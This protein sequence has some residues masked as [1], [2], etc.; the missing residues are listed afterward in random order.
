[1]TFVWPQLLWSLLLVPLLAAGYAAWSR[2]RSAARRE[3]GGLVLSAGPGRGR[4]RHLPPALFLLSI[5]LLLVSVGRP[6][7]VVTLPAQHETVVLAIDVS[8]SMRATDVKPTRLA[9]A[10][11]AARAFVATQ[12]RSTRIGLVTFAGVASLVQ[13]P[14]DNREDVLQAIERM[15][16]QRGTAIGSAIVVSLATIFPRDGIDLRMVGR[17]PGAPAE[18]TRE[19]R[20]D[21]ARGRGD[22]LEDL[23]TQSQAPR[24]TPGSYDSAVIVLLSDGQSTTGPE[25]VAAAKL[26]AER[27]VRVYTVG[28]GTA[29]GEVLRTDGWSM[30]VS[31]DEGQLK[32]VADLTRGEYFQAADAAELKRVYQSMSSRF[33]MEK[34]EL[35]IGALFAAGAVLLA[36]L[37][38]G[39]SVAWY[40][41]VL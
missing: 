41:R 6:A 16:P 20:R 36:L 5:A 12:P 22:P 2:R 31:L 4:W 24:A 1:M 13:P 32:T 19:Q 34:K 11:E 7:A 28:V 33:V 23:T 25:P 26:A 8:G 17:K 39:L 14:T 21:A 40:G 10:Q 9:A 15:Q 30:R 37:A 3:L 38:A 29:K 27:G 35:E 18:G